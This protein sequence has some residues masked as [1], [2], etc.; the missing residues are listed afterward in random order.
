MGTKANS[1]HLIGLMTPPNGQ[2][3]SKGCLD[4]RWQMMAHSGWALTILFIV[5]VHSIS[6]EF[7]IAPGKE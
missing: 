1:P 6:V 3:D 7:S 2:A 5:S 4:R